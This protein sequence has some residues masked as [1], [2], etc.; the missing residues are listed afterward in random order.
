MEMCFRESQGYCAHH[1]DPGR[2]D[3]CLNLE[4]IKIVQISTSCII[5]FI[6]M[7]KNIIR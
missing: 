3:D 4:A 5:L 1:D 7:K 6:I 2:R